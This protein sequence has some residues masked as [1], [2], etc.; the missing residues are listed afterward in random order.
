MSWE[1]AGAWAGSA[2]LFTGVGI[3]CLAGLLLSTLSLSG[4]WC[5]VGAAAL[6][7]AV[8]SAPFPSWG[9]VAAFAAV[10]AIIE[11]LEFVSSY[12]GVTRRGGSKTGAFVAML[13]GLAGAILGAF[14]PPPIIGSLVCMMAGAFG[15]AYW[16]ERRRAKANASH[17]AW[18]TVLAKLAVIALKFGAT[19]A[20]AVILIGG[21]L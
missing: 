15:G 7:A 14:I 11:G 2:A 17:I 12:L 5:V 21:L 9:L 19:A 13:G 10:A 3:L 16:I 4:T 8:R 6:A 18:G 20:M 1:A